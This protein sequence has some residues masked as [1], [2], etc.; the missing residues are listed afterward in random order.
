MEL[1]KIKVRTV[2]ILK[3]TTVMEVN[4]KKVALILYAVVHNF[5]KYLGSYAL[6]KYK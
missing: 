5:K 1:I 4:L 3:F 2:R 6:W